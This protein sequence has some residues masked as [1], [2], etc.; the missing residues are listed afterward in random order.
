MWNVI[1]GLLAVLGVVHVVW[2]K[3]EFVLCPISMTRQPCWTKQMHVELARGDRE[4]QFDININSCKLDIKYA[5]EI[6]RQNIQN[7]EECSVEA[8]NLP[9]AAFLRMKMRASEIASCLKV[10]SEVQGKAWQRQRNRKLSNPITALVIWIRDSAALIEIHIHSL[11][12][13]LFVVFKLYENDL[14]CG[15]WES[16][17]CK[18][19]IKIVAVHNILITINVAFL[20]TRQSH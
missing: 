13:T 10:K 5:A 15:K 1:V 16:D 9:R 20:F 3:Y 8:I 17:G 7:W 19:I 14:I 11:H 4:Q 12:C 18:W 2:A 6:K